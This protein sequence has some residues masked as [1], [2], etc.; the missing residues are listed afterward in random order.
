MRDPLP[1]AILKLFRKC[2][3]DYR[4]AKKGSSYSSCNYHKSVNV[5]NG[6]ATK[7]LSVIY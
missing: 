1:Y 4:K 3:K 5:G 2:E 6:D 7:I